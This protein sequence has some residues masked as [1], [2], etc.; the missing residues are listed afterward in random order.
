MRVLESTSPLC[1]PLVVGTSVL[2]RHRFDAN[3]D[4]TVHFDPD[5]DSDTDPYPSFTHVGKTGKIF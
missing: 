1:R 5:P 3:P 2:D 4:P